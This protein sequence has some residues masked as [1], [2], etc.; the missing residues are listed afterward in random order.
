MKHHILLAALYLFAGCNLFGGDI[1]QRGTL[2]LIPDDTF[3]QGIDW[4]KL[5]IANLSTSPKPFERTHEYLALAP[6][7]T[8]YVVEYNSNTAGTVY[9]FTPNGTLASTK[10]PMTGKSNPNMWARHLELPAVNSRNELWIS[11]HARINRCDAKGNVLSVTSL[12][13]SIEDLFFLKGGELAILGNYSIRIWNP[14][15]AEE[16]VIAKFPQRSPF[17]ISLPMQ[18]LEPAKQ[19]KPRGVPGTIVG[20]IGFVAPHTMGKLIFAGTPEGNLVVGYSD[21]PEIQLLSPEGRKLNSFTLP[22]QR[23]ALSPEQRAQAMQRISQSLDSLAA[24][25]KAPD[26]AIE[27]ARQQLKDYPSEVTYYS[28]LLTDDQGNILIFLTKPN[29]PANLEF[30]AFSPTGKVLGTCRLILPQDISLRL[31]RRKQLEVRDG[32]LFALIHKNVSGKKQVR[33]ARF[34]FN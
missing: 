25:R 33:L 32:W 1:Y 26:N 5:F 3:A 23:P 28:N 2:N 14:Q 15:T 9:R 19:E 34:K 27:R 12:K 29:D 18:P 10:A 20:G 31:D 21:S 30:M 11:E 16:T 13:Q 17:A 4:S 24:G 8:I 6:D 7:K 22:I